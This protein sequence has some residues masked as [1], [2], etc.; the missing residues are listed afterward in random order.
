MGNIKSP[1]VQ[2]PK[3]TYQS[4]FK[5]HR[6]T[7]SIAWPVHSFNL[8]NVS[9][10]TISVCAWASLRHI[11]L[12]YDCAETV[13]EFPTLILICSEIEF[14]SSRAATGIYAYCR[15]NTAS[16]NNHLLKDENPRHQSGL[17]TFI[18]KTNNE[19]RGLCR[20]EADMEPSVDSKL[21]LEPTRTTRNVKQGA[22]SCQTIGPK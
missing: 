8:L 4:E 5:L 7:P 16:A 10:Y 9:G 17:F 22:G 15:A 14:F 3:H 18:S 20:I 21:E 13:L 12:N 19:Q 11:K 6:L 2:S 1:W